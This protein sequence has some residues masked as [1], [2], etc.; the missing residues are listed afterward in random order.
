MTDFPLSPEDCQT[1]PEVRAG[2]DALDAELVALPSVVTG[3]VETAGDIDY[4]VVSEQALAGTLALPLASRRLSRLMEFLDSTDAEGL[5]GRLARWC[6]SE[7][8]E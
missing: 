7:G 6:E 4:V 1:M 5:H 8:G 3:C 2:V